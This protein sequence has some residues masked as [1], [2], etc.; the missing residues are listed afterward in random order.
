[1]CWVQ[2]SCGS[3][4]SCQ[5]LMH[6][7]DGVPSVCPEK[8]WVN[9]FSC[10]FIL[11]LLWKQE[12][13]GLVRK[14]IYTVTGH[15]WLFMCHLKEHGGKYTLVLLAPAPELIGNWGKLTGYQKW[16]E[17]WVQYGHREVR[18]ERI[19]RKTTEKCEGHPPYKHTLPQI[20]P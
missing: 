12:S 18:S 16:W 14:D 10:S 20:C 5:V 15:K 17:V 2:S 9:Y 13:G 11:V 3:T 8:M 4:S 19:V 6:T 7:L 1:M